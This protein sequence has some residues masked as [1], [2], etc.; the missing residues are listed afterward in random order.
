MLIYNAKSYNYVVII[1]EREKLHR[2]YQSNV[3]NNF[4]FFFNDNHNN[5]KPE[6]G[7]NYN[8]TFAQN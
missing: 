6:S 1:L 7:N 2:K 8:D 5:V 4:F 3:T